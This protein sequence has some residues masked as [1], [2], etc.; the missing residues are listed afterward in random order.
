MITHQLALMRRE[1]WEHRSIY[2]APIAVAIVMSLISIAGMVTASAFDNEIR[3]AILG[4]SSIV[5]DAERQA[6]MT[7]F[8]LGTSWIF[9]FALAILTVFYALDSLYALRQLQ[10]LGEVHTP[11]VADL[12]VA[13]IKGAAV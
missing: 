3:M 8:F 1:V 2:V 11:S 10:G 7:V 4:A 5:G 9:L 6:A 13:K 12:F